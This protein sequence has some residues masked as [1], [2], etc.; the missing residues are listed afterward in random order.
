MGHRVEEYLSTIGPGERLWTWTQT[1][2]LTEIRRLL[3]LLGVPRAM[4]CTLK[5]FRAGKATA[6]A[7]AG[8]T[9][10]EIMRAG[11]WRSSAALRYINEEAVDTAEFLRQALDESDKE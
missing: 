7:A 2:L 9:L 10:A 5:D 4:E 3:T 8:S 1:Q 6:L 11:E